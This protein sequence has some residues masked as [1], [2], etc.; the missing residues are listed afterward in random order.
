MPKLLCKVIACTV[1]MSAALFSLAP[2]AAADAIVILPNGTLTGVSISFVTPTDLS[3]DIPLAL[4][5]NPPLYAGQHLPKLV[6][7]ILYPGTNAPEETLT[8]KNCLVTSLA[9]SSGTETADFYFEQI[10]YKF[11]PAP[12]PVPEPGS[13]GLVVLGLVALVGCAYEECGH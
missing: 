8:L 1:V 4:N 7:E 9:T 3:V 11:Y 5:P 13:L 2:R 6:A 12:P 10:S